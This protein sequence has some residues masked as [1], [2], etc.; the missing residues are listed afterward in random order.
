MMIEWITQS[1]VGRVEG[2]PALGLWL[3]LRWIVGSVGA[4]WGGGGGNW[5]IPKVRVRVGLRVK[6]RVRRMQDRVKDRVKDRVRNMPSGWL[7]VV[8]D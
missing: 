7:G 6:D 1:Q 4:G 3:E 8:L 2:G 5:E